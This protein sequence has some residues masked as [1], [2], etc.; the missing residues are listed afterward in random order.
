MLP[1]LSIEMGEWD[2][3]IGR[4][5]N[6]VLQDQRHSAKLKAVLLSF[7]FRKFDISK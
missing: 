3:D 7:F 2:L 5:I 1:L 6:K 4:S